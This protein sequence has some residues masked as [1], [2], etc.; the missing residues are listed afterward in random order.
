M[1]DL[2]LHFSSLF[3]L[4]PLTESTLE[5]VQLVHP[6]IHHSMLLVYTDYKVS[7]KHCEQ[8]KSSDKLLEP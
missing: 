8:S 1:Q 3:Y 5:Y 2:I 4:L 7:T 6:P